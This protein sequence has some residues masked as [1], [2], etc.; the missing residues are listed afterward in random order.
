MRGLVLHKN[1]KKHLKVLLYVGLALVSMFWAVVAVTTYWQ[2]TYNRAM[3]N[4]AAILADAVAKVEGI[5]DINSIAPGKTS[6]NLPGIA[7]SYQRTAD[8]LS[9]ENFTKVTIINSGGRAINSDVAQ[10]Q[11]VAEKQIEATVYRLRVAAD[12]LLTLQKFIEYDALTD[13][14]AYSMQNDPVADERLERTRNG[15]NETI[16]A[17][18]TSKLPYRKEILD[19]LQPLESKAQTIAPNNVSA[20]ASDVHA[21]QQQVLAIIEADYENNTNANIEKLRDFSR[22]YLQKRS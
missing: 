1:R 6:G 13:L 7:T 18:S 3:S 15:I 20:W 9:N 17:T 14:Q 16:T 5:S 19:V 8:E 21:A 11:Q 10:L 4:N 2:N 22:Q 12:G